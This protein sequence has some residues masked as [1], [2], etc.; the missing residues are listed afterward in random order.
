[1]Q[2]SRAD[3]LYLDLLTHCVAGTLDHEHLIP[4]D[5]PSGIVKRLAHD[6]LRRRGLALATRRHFE[7]DALEARATWPPT[8]LTLLGRRRLEN[9]RRCAADV[10]AEGVPGDLIEAGVWRGGAALL[11]KAV[12]ASHGDLER[13]VWL[14]DSFQGLPEPDGD[15]YPADAGNVLWSDPFLAVPLETVKANF[16]RYG[17]LDER[18][19]FLEGWFKDTLPQLREETFAVVRL[20]GDLY[21]STMDGLVNLYPAL[22]PGGFLIVDD[23]GDRRWGAHA[24]VD[25]YRAANGGTEPILEIDASGIYWRKSP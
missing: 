14:A 13:R 10:L 4:I 3:D 18:V 24:A 25:E 21:E 22:S 11:M 7:P 15:R 23:Y 8:G 6:V 17:L 9:V 2:A 20:D 12:L 16:E 19:L 5:R 1:V